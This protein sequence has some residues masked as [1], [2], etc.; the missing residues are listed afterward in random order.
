M[1]EFH[2]RLGKL[3]KKTS[4]EST[5]KR[6]SYMNEIAEV[7]GITKDKPFSGKFYFETINT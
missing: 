6:I 7:F 5:K 4:K 1:L 3:P 2:K